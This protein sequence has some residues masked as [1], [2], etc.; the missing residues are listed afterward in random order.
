L[1]WRSRVLCFFSRFWASLLAAPTPSHECGLLPFLAPRLRQL[2]PLF[3]R[4]A[5]TVARA[6]APLLVF[7]RVTRAPSALDHHDLV[8]RS[9]FFVCLVGLRAG[10]VVF[11]AASPLLFPSA[12]SFFGVTC[13]T[14]GRR[15]APVCCACAVARLAKQE[16]L[17]FFVGSCFT[18]AFF[19]RPRSTGRGRSRAS[20]TSLSILFPSAYPDSNMGSSF[21]GAEFCTLQV[22]R[23]SVILDVIDPR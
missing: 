23:I 18:W 17:L 13:R 21:R 2:G 19:L 1:T 20:S 5:P 9:M 15:G 12:P 4:G 7:F 16:F 11:D 8:A 22:V 3:A 10:R 14:S 6:V